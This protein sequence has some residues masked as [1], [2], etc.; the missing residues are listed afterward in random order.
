[1]KIFN[2]LY[3]FEWDEGNQD[4]N[5]LKHNV[6]NSESEEIFFN[7]PLIIAEDEKHSIIESRY[8]ALGKTD[9][10]RLL[11]IVFTVRKEKIRIISA[12]DMKKKEKEIYH[13]KDE[14]NT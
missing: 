8:Y 9:H 6:L 5:L 14:K 3:E 7:Q 13:A 10:D 1:M 2:K 11:F 12:R 4:K